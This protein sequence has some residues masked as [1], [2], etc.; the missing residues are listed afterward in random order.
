MLPGEYLG[1]NGLFYNVLNILSLAE[2]GIGTAMQYAFYEPAAV[3]DRR[4][5]QQLMN[6]LPAFVSYGSCG[7]YCNWPDACS[8]FGDPGQG[9]GAD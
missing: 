6:F 4:K 3:E 9:R 8:F 5:L 7:N 1:I 2:L